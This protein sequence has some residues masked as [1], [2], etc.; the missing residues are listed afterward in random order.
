MEI[1]E[2]AIHNPSTEKAV[3]IRIRRK[4]EDDRKTANDRSE[5]TEI[6]TKGIELLEQVNQ[7]LNTAVDIYL[8]ELTPPSIAM[9][10]ELQAQLTRFDSDTLVVIFAVAKQMDLPAKMQYIDEHIQSF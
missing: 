4:L 10:E 5:S 6:T 7:K 3:L 9:T 8:S 2:R 1:F